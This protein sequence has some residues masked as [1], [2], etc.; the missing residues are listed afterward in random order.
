MYKLKEGIT[1]ENVKTAIEFVDVTNLDDKF[2]N[3]FE[4]VELPKVELKEQHEDEYSITDLNEYWQIL[5]KHNIL[6]NIMSACVLL[7]KQHLKD[8]I[9]D[10][11][12]KLSVAFGF[13]LIEAK[14]DK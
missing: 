5:L 11:N 10:F 7:N 2:D 3:Y 14:E 12:E 4:K 9:S 1:W 6:E 13:E 8:S